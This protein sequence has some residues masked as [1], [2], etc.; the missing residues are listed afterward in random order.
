MGLAYFLRLQVA[1]VVRITLLGKHHPMKRYQLWSSRED[2]DNTW[3]LKPL[4]PAPRPETPVCQSGERHNFGSERLHRT[5]TVAAKTT[6]HF[7]GFLSY[8]ESFASTTYK[9]FR[10]A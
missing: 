1:T 7:V 9:F 5:R 2:T 3:S 8:L 6:Q 4:Q 10:L